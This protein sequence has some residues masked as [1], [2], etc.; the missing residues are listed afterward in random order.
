[1]TALQLIKETCLQNNPAQNTE[2]MLMS[3]PI[4]D[5]MVIQWS[6]EIFSV[7][8]KVDLILFDQQ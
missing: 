4:L 6:H 5:C 7:H 8:T 1:M 3:S 2:Y